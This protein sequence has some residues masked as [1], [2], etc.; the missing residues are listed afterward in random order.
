M[1]VICLCPNAVN[2]VRQLRERLWREVQR[3]ASNLVRR[4]EGSY[5]IACSATQEDDRRNKRTKA[6][7]AVDALVA[8]GSVIAI[9]TSAASR[10]TGLGWPVGL[11][12]RQRVAEV[13]ARLQSLRAAIADDT[14]DKAKIVESTY[15]DQVAVPTGEGVSFQ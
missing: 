15:V 12:D 8:E 7:A 2:V 10:E 6:K 9:L 13:Q 1:G 11:V 14:W 5:R 3:A 4:A